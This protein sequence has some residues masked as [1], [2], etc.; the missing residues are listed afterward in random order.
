MPLQ[1]DTYLEKTHYRTSI[2]TTAIHGKSSPIISSPE[3]EQFFY[4]PKYVEPS[5]K[6]YNPF[7]KVILRQLDVSNEFTNSLLLKK[8]S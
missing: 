8:I 7:Q 2:A 1:K 4:E 5:T 3:E 6:V